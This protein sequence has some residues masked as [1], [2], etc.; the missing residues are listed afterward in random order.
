MKHYRLNNYFKAF[1]MLVMLF[2]AGLNEGFTQNITYDN[3]PPFGTGSTAV[4]TSGGIVFNFTTNKPITLLNFRAATTATTVYTATIWYNQTKINGKPTITNMTPAFGW[5]SL[6]SASHAG[7]G[8]AALATIP[9]T[10]NLDMNPGD[11]FAFFL[12]FSGG[13]VYSN[14]SANPYNPTYTNGTVTII[15]DSS[16]A[17]TRNATA[18]F[19][20]LRQLSGGIIYKERQLSY[21]NASVSGLVAP[22]NFCPGTQDVK[23]RI[24]N[25]GKNVIN[26]VTVQWMLDN[27]LQTPINWVSPLD[28]L[29]GN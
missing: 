8:T 17:F 15:A 3:V 23:V 18:W 25:N 1:V 5:Q 21:N 16:C 10:M 20:P 24:K 9:V 4:G 27:V 7:A 11:T 19:G 29:G 2:M 28:T 26:N 13:N 6:G 12:Q 14:S 22:T